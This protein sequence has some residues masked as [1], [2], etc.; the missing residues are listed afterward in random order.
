MGNFSC[1]MKEGGEA[2]L[3]I[4]HKMETIVIKCKLFL[5]DGI[6]KLEG[7]SWLSQWSLWP[8]QAFLH[9][10]LCSS[11]SHQIALVLDVAQNY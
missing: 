2:Y 10:I 4:E 1:H 7:H 3:S 8:Y 11:K 9:Y 5:V 6:N